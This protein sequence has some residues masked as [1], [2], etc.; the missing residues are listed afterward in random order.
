MFELGRPRV[1]ADDELALLLELEGTRAGP[2]GRRRCC[3]RSRRPAAL[4]DAVGLDRFRA[5]VASESVRRSPEPVTTALALGHSAMVD[6]TELALTVDVLGPLT[7]RVA[8]RA[9]ERTGF[10][11]P[12][13]SGAARAGGRPR[14]DHR[15]A[16]RLTVARRPSGERCPGALQPRLPVAR[17]PR[18]VWRTGWSGTHVGTASGSSRSS[19]TSTPFAGS[20]PTIRRPPSICG[21][22]RRS[23]SSARCPW[24][25]IES[26]GPGRAAPPARRRGARGT[27]DARRPSTWSSR[28]LPPRPH[29]RFESERRCCTYGLWRRTDA[30]RKRWPPRRPSGA[31]WSTRPGSTRRR[32]WPSWSSRSPRARSPRRPVARVSPGPTA[33]WSDDSTT[34]RRWFGSSAPTPSSRSPAPA[35][36]ARP[37]WPSTSP[38][39]PRK[40]SSSRSPSSTAPSGS[41]EAVASTWACASPARSVPGRSPPRSPT[42][43]CSWCWTT[44][45][46]SSVAC[47]DLVVA[48]R[49]GAPGVRVLATSRD[50]LQV[51][52]EYVVRLQPLPG[53]ARRLRPRRHCVG[54][55]ACARSSNTRV[56]GVLASSYRRTKQRTSSRCCAGWTGCRWGSSW[57][58]G[59]WR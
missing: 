24:L 42:A 41:C 52:G 49:R 12:R 33:R 50:T 36:S 54:S 56:G 11:A 10:P 47:R 57:P 38:Q 21:G 35:V 22:D 7:L 13:P 18:T 8:G 32:H 43:S 19:S 20:R 44:A 34:A 25:E 30:R 4:V 23:P 48:L 46:T 31:D 59:R 26:V 37:G 1:C 55:R 39:T 3:D 45:S 5:W 58:R 28:P 29:R 2:Q 14:A 51:P 17:P 40:Q 53:A 27:A 15:T 6:R 9:V 16:G